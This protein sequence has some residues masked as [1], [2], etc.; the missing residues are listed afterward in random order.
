MLASVKAKHGLQFLICRRNARAY[1][2]MVPDLADVADAIEKLSK[3]LLYWGSKNREDGIGEADLDHKI[4]TILWSWR[5]EGRKR[6]EIERRGRR[7]RQRRGEKLPLRRVVKRSYR[8]SS[9][10]L[11]RLILV[12]MGKYRSKFFSYEKICRLQG[13][14]YREII[15]G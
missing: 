9:K 2:R 1:D 12:E 4:A 7:K 5:K 14:Q 15:L 6:K 13:D 11:I 10:E 8:W 3:E